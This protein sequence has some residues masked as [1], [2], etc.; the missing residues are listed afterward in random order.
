GFATPSL[1]LAD[2]PLSQGNG[3][4]IYA[5]SE[6]QS[7]AQGLMTAA[8]MVQPLVTQWL[9]AKRKTPVTIID[10]PEQQDLTWEQGTLLVT[11]ITDQPPSTS[12]EMIAHALAHGAFQSPY[13]WLNEGVPTF[14]ETLWIEHNAD[15]THALEKLESERSALAFAEP[16]TPG[17]SPGE[18]LLHASDPIYYRIKAAYVLWMLRD[19]AGDMQLAAALQAYNPAADTTPGYFQKLIEQSSGKDL[20]WFFDNWVYHDRGLPDLSIAAFHSSPAENAGQYLVAIDIMNDGF[21]ETEVPVTVRS[22]SSTLTN[23]VLLPGKTRTVHRMLV[24][25]QPTQVIVNDG[26]VPEVA[27][28]IHQRDINN[29]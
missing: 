28:D 1:F 7:N 26:T 2:W 22:G 16:A 9:G 24:E 14:V 19:L 15:R 6:D 29:Q 20:Q 27:S 4:Q 12:A 13:E 11:G 21:A 17:D 5:R 18:D 10:L 8:T 25:G 3:L 23:R